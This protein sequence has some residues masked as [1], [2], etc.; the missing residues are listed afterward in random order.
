M[1]TVNGEAIYDNTCAQ[2]MRTTHARN[3][4]AQ[5]MR[6]SVLFCAGLPGP[7][8]A[9]AGLPGPARSCPGLPRP[10]RACPGL[11]EPPNLNKELFTLLDL[12]VSSLRR[13]HANLLCIVPILT[14]D[15]R[16]ESIRTVA[17]CIPY[18]NGGRLGRGRGAGRRAATQD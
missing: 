10:T 2:Y 7:A 16:R 5:H 13:G 11:P 6:N 1:A 9:C 15:P 8:R 17:I 12:C 18:H 14:D 3:T 4:C